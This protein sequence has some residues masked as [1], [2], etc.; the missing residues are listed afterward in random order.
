MKV[1]AREISLSAA[2]SLEIL[3]FFCVLAYAVF[4]FMVSQELINF[5]AQVTGLSKGTIERYF[6]LLCI[7]CFFRP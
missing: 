4:L 7:K 1:I 5:F 2:P 6:F 3:I